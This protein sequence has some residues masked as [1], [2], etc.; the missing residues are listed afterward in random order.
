MYEFSERGRLFSLFIRIGRVAS[1]VICVSKCCISAD[2]SSI[3]QQQ[4]KSK[5]S[6][7]PPT[8]TTKEVID[9]DIKVEL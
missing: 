7:S 6:T 1:R 8:P 4:A 9:T 3:I 2:N 5:S